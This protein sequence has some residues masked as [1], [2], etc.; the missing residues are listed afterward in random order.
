MNMKRVLAAAFALAILASLV[1]GNPGSS[2][3]K[4][5]LLIDYRHNDLA[6]VSLSKDAALYFLGA[7]VQ[8]ADEVALM[9]FSDVRGLLVVEDFTTDRDKVRER[10]ATMTDVPGSGDSMTDY[11]AWMMAQSAGRAGTPISHTGSPSTG[12]EEAADPGNEVLRSASNDVLPIPEVRSRSVASRGRDYVYLGSMRD[13]A[14]GLAEIPGRKH[15]IYFSLGFPASRYHSDRTF[16]E[17]FDEMATGFA[18]AEAPV[19]T[20]NTLGRRQDLRG[21]SEKVDFL[22][23]KFA[24]GSG[25]LYYAYVERYEEIAADIGRVAGF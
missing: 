3:R 9:L 17:R 5:L 16:R 11:A 19:Y 23:R 15:I 21:L 14:D 22:L 8:E 2:P 18:A 12:G 13:F 24:D 20:I 1:P 6:G 25:G 7:E 4:F 10:L